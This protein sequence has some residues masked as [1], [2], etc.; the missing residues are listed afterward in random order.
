MVNHYTIWKYRLTTIFPSRSTSTISTSLIHTIRFVS[1]SFI[2]SNVKSI[3][4]YIRMYKLRMFCGI[5]NQ[6]YGHTDS[7]CW[8]LD[9]K[10]NIRN[11]RTI[12]RPYNKCYMGISSYSHHYI[13]LCVCLVEVK[14]ELNILNF[15]QD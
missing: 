3:L 5:Y 6:I 9:V 2:Y 4:S 8:C 7:H 1:I 15:E 11:H 13:E 10:T 14:L 12:E